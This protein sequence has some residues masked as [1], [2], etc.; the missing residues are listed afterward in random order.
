MLLF[1]SCLAAPRAGG[2]KAEMPAPAERAG[3][4]RHL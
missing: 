3:C 4:W 2:S 1:T